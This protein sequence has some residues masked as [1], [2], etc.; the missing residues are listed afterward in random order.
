MSKTVLM[1]F[2]PQG[3]TLKVGIGDDKIP[4]VSHTKFLGVILDEE[5]SWENT[6]HTCWTNCKL[7]T[8]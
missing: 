5:L 1:H 8:H 4:Q 7:S 3:H 6:Y 2:W